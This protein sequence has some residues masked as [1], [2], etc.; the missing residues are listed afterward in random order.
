MKHINEYLL[1]KSKSKTSLDLP[2]KADFN[3]VT[4]FLD[5]KDFARLQTSK[6]TKEVQHIVDYLRLIEPQVASNS[7]N[8]YDVTPMVGGPNSYLVRFF[9]NVPFTKDAKIFLTYVTD[10]GNEID[11]ESMIGIYD[12]ENMHYDAKRVGLEEFWEEA[13]K[14]FE[15]Q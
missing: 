2:R 8:S 15:W 12:K 4:E 7:K 11:R 9:K 10:N 6:R 3:E 1:S 5:S 13:R 14:Y